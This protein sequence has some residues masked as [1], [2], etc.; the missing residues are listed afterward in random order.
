VRLKFD[1]IPYLREGLK[2]NEIL[3]FANPV[4]IEQKL[5]IVDFKQQASAQGIHLTTLK[6]SSNPDNASGRHFT[7]DVFATGC[8]ELPILT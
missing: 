2:C 1:V 5:L 7:L 8:T 3:L 4:D 6:S